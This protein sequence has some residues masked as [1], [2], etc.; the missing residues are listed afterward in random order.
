MSTSMVPR[1]P[2]MPYVA[3]AT[4]TVLGVLVGAYLLYQVRS[5]A[6]A[7][8]LGFFLAV[9]FDPFL[10]RLQHQGL[11]RGFAVL[12]FFLLL[13][14]VIG[15]F[16]F[17]ALQPL[18]SQLNDLVDALPDLIQRLSDRD[19]RLG[20]FLQES[21]FEQQAR[22]ALSSLP[23]YAA[24][25]VGT[26]FGILGAI[27]G[28]IFSVF[29]VFALTAYFM[30]ALPRIRAFAERALESP[31]RVRV[32]TEAL[33][34]VGGYVTGQLTICVLAGVTSYIALTVIGVPYAAVLAVAVAVFDAIPQVGATI[35]AV[36]VTL[37]AL[38]ESVPVALITLAYFL[39]YQQFE[40]YVI[41][42]RIFSRAVN[43]SPVAVFI[44]VLVGASLAGVIGALVALPIA[45]AMKTIFGY[46]FRD[47]LAQMGRST[48]WDQLEPGEKEADG[49]RVPAE[50]DPVH[51]VHGSH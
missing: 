51:V 18:I 27:V 14:A 2:P 37:V 12:T 30:M 29:T 8:F 33:G 17:I 45:A 32:M 21:N 26:V 10:T 40:N 19:T 50:S 49:P 46:T 36:V 43:L 5:V 15:G 9:G 34:K 23:A 6:L 39:L 25:S 41:G 38:T 24:S 44:A 4:L 11:R 31:A 48:T 47:K 16:L 1:R 20:E 42:P 3:K 28:G 35:G 7:V 22:D 13:F